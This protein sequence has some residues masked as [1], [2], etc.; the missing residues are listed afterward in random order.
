MTEETKTSRKL[1]LKASLAAVA[2]LGV[3]VAAG[4]TAIKAS[5]PSIEMAPIQPVAIGGLTDNGSVVTL[6]G[7]VSEVY[8]PM[9][10]LQDGSGRALIDSRRRPGPFGIGMTSLVTTGATVTIQGHFHDG[11]VRASFLIGADG[12]VTALGGPP[13]GPRGPRFSGPDGEREGRDGPPPPPPADG[14][15][16]PPPAVQ[17]PVVPA[18]PVTGNSAG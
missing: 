7:K 3:G 1:P 12:K 2:L 5:G 6:R 13:H 10:V 17:P 11:I 8:G 15:A 18:Q 14:A 4:A 9:F 16:P